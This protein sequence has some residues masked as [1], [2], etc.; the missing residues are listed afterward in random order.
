MVQ[1]GGAP[2]VRRLICP[3]LMVTTQNSDGSKPLS[4]AMLRTL[5]IS[6][7]VTRQGVVNSSNRRK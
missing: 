5:A 3:E 2:V 1:T 4:P 7:L 6:G